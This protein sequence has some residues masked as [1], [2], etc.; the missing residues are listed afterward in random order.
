MMNRV[1]Y[2]EPLKGSIPKDIILV[3]FSWLLHKSY[4]AYQHLSIPINGV[5]VVTG[6][7]YGSCRS[8]FSLIK[9][10]P[11]ASVILC[12]DDKTSF[13]KDIQED[14]KAGRERQDKDAIYSKL[15]ETIQ[16]MSLLPN[17]Y[18]SFGDD[19]E[20]DD[21][22]FTLA[23]MFTEMRTIYIYTG[24]DDLM[25][26]IQ[27][28]VVI[29]RNIKGKLAE[30]GPDQVMEKYG[31]PPDRLA[32][33]WAII[34]DSSDNIKGIPRFPSKAAALIAS[35]PECNA[36]GVVS[37]KL[38]EKY[39]ENLEL[40]EKNLSLLRLTPKPG[41]FIYKEEG[42]DAPLDKYKCLSLRVQIR[43]MLN[44]AGR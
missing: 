28:N 14:Y 25:Q 43:E 39:M 44:E 26:A 19:L 15:D 12:L 29:W 13:R 35:D 17:V 32:H 31:V 40:V 33:L 30:I 2:I 9:K 27:G 42:S 7:I 38:V 4:Y 20:A 34:G 23:S 3:D 36:G 16:V 11:Y 5:T 10:K 22:M 37:P 18:V 41:V 1:D 6:D 21:V 24:D 8:L